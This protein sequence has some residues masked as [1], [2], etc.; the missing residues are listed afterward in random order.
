VKLRGKLFM[1]H[2]LATAVAVGVVVLA[3]RGIAIRATRSHMEEMADVVGGMTGMMTDLEAAVAEGVTEAVAGGLLAAV[4]VAVLASYL[5]SGWLTRTV[6][7]MAHAARRIAAGEYHQRVEYRGRDEIAQFA[8]SFNYMAARLEET[9]SVRRELL[10]TI[11]HELRTP[12][13]NIQGYM[14][15]LIDGVVPEE[16]AIY[17]LVHRE[18]GRLARL[19][20]EIERLSR[21][22]AGVDQVDLGPIDP[23]GL[24][25]EV[26]ERL[27]P[28]FEEKGV[29]LNAHT[30]GGLP[31]VL[32]DEDRLVQVLVNL[33][34]NALK[35][36]RPEGRVI[37]RARGLGEQVRFEVS[38]TGI[39]IPPEDLPHIFERFYRVDKSRSTAGGGLGLG[40]AVSRSLIER[41]G[42]SVGAESRPGQGT[43]VWF[44]LPAAGRPPA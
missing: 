10:A 4:V 33:L 20:T 14:E 9:E 25:N 16:P 23:T 37:V 32:A 6:E 13:T 15:G 24:V 1:S 5:V 44:V 12:L 17:Q 27:R 11:T 8:H 22:E 35:Y 2:L 40:L 7:R 28:Q 39:G 34:A 38:D 29:Q 21:I 26:I 36:T 31:P 41:M 30:D 3:V 19:V 18:A 43:T 42:G